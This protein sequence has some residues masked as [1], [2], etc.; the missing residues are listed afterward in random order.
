MWAAKQYLSPSFES[1]CAHKKNEFRCC[2]IEIAE[3]VVIS[4]PPMTHLMGL[5]YHSCSLPYPPYSFET[6]L[7]ALGEEGCLR[8]RKVRVNEQKNYL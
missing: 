4:T 7:T 5:P 1:A 3:G 8:N 2:E 6:E